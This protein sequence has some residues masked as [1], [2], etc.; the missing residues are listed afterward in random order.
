MKMP[1]IKDIKP[2]VEINDY[3]LYLF[4]LLVVVGVAVA[5]FLGWLLIKRINLKRRENR[6]K[7]YLEAL[8]NIDWSDPKAAAYKITKYGRFLATDDKRREIF[9][10]LVPLLN[11]YKYKKEVNQSVDSKTLREF[12]LFKQVCDESI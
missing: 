12:E 6:A 8:H 10:N 3:S 4:I 1:E 7:L 2:P 5:L 11:Q 9:N